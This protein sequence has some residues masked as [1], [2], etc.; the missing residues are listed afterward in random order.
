M[1]KLKDKMNDLLK[2]QKV[3][4]DKFKQVLDNLK[5]MEDKNDLKKYF[6]KWKNA[7]DQIKKDNLDNL[8]NKLNDI[9]TKAKK[10]SEDQ[11]KK[12]FLDNLKKNNDVAKGVE[13]LD[14][15]INTKPKKDAFETLKKNSG[16]SEGFRVL[17]KLCKKNDDKSKNDFLERLKKNAESQR[18]LE[19]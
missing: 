12:D 3:K 16:M 8:A 18:A 4:E 7:S 17:D 15:F 14:D 10:E 5:K 2:K 6:D 9:L 19:E 1:D 13:K 11:N